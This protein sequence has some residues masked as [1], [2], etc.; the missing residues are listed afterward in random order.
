[1]PE[2][3]HLLRR[4]LRVGVFVIEVN[5]A[6]RIDDV[7]RVPWS[8]AMGTTVTPPGVNRNPRQRVAVGDGEDRIEP[9]LVI[10]EAQH[11]GGSDLADVFIGVSDAQVPPRSPVIASLNAYL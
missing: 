11:A 3:I 1:M 6:G 7:A 2:S 4:G 8:L 5:T 9:A 10:S